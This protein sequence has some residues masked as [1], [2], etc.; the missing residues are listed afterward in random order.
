[1]LGNDQPPKVKSRTRRKLGKTE[2]L[3]AAALDGIPR[4]ACTTEASSLPRISGRTELLPPA[5][6]VTVTVK[7]YTS[8]STVHVYETLHCH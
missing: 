5:A 4:C 1:M 7:M 8:F 6:L 3:L 2:L